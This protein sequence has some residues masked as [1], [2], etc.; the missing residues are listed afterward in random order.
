MV[1]KDGVTQLSFLPNSTKPLVA[2]MGTNEQGNKAF[3]LV[4]SDVSSATGDGVCLS[5][6][7]V[8]QYFTLRKDQ[9]E[10]FGYTPDPGTTYKLKLNSINDVITKKSGG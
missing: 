2:Y 8:C 6:T 9:V 10:S 3:F 5:T 1:E 7:P 4:S